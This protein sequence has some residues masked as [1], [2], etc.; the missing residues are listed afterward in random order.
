MTMPTFAELLKKYK[1]HIGTSYIKIAEAAGYK[2]RQTIQNWFKGAL[3]KPDNRDKV[4]AIVDLW[5]LTLPERQEFLQ[6]AF[7]NEEQNVNLADVMFREYLKEILNELSCSNP[8]VRVLLTPAN[9]AAA[10]L[11]FSEAIL[12]QAKRQYSPSTV[13]CIQPPAGSTEDINKCFSILGEQCG[14]KNVKDAVDFQLKLKERLNNGDTLLLLIHRLEKCYPLL[15][16]EIQSSIRSVLE[17]I[18]FSHLHIM[19]WGGEQLAELLYSQSNDKHSVLN[20]AQEVEQKPKLTGADIQA[21]C[22]SHFDGLELSENELDEN[23]VNEILRISGGHP[24]LLLDCL[25]LIQKEANLPWEDYPN[26]LSQK[27]YV[28]N[29]FIPFAQY[30][31]EKKRVYKWIENRRLG[32]AQ[33]NIQDHLLRKLYWKDMLIEKKEADGKIMLYWRCE[34][35]RIA[36]KE[37]LKPQNGDNLELIR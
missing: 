17:E 36:G 3:P 33:S 4:E 10:N 26:K 2:S 22:Q 27:S 34:A 35:L 8:P 24:Q 5:R 37:I 19:L 20:I 29:L 9:W 30:E 13:L 6:A 11:P 25:K 23:T 18:G 1:K 28:Q 15:Q 31:S 12:A 16:K 7:P 32:K 14:F 21:L